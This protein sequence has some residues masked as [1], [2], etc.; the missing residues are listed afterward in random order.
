MEDFFKEYPFTIALCLVMPGTAAWFGA[1]R[2]VILVALLA[3]LII[4]TTVDQRKK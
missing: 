3:A 1:N 4:G 2:W